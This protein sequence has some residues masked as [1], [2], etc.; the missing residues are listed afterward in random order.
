MAREILF[1]KHFFRSVWFFPAILLL[2]VIIFT[3]LGINGSS[4]GTFRTI[5]YGT[6]SPDPALIVNKPRD[7]RSDEWLVSTQQI[8]AQTEDNF[9]RNNHN[10][11]NGED[12][13]TFDVPYRDWSV[14]FK[15]QNWAFFVLPLDNAFAFKWWSLG[16]LLIVSC[17]FF[18]LAILPG[19]RL[20]AAT[21]ASSLF[22]SAFIQWWYVF[23]TLA[24]V[25]YPL[26]IMT[27]VVYLFRQKIRWKQLALTLL[28][29]YLMTCFALVLYPP[30]QIPCAL[31][32]F[33]FLVGYVLE[34]RKL[35]DKRELI[36]KLLLVAGSTVIA[37]AIVGAFIFTRM[38]TVNSITHTAY[39]GKRTMQSG[40]FFFNHFMSSHLG[41]QFI[42][43]KN[44][45]QYLIDGKSPSNQSETSNFLL[46][47]PFLFLP[48]L[49]LIYKD[50]KRKKDLDWPLILLNGLFV[51]FL[52]EMFV[53]AFTPISKLFF[54]HQVGGARSL[55]GVGLLNLI[56]FALIIRR[57]SRQKSAAITLPHA[58][59]ILYSFAVLVVELHFGLHAH[60]YGTFIL[61]RFV[62]LFSLPIPIVIYLLLTKRYLLAAA[63]YL[64]F[65]VFITIKINPLYQ[66]LG[67]L[68][69]NPLSIAIDR[70]GQ[71][72]DK[73]WVS[74]GGYLEHVAL[75]EGER[76]ISGVYNY[77]QFELWKPIPNTPANNYNRYAHVGFQITDDPTM[78]ASL[79]LVTAD[80]F[81]IKANSCDPYLRKLNIG[82]V[83]T[84]AV[85][86]AG[87]TTLEETV[88]FPKAT[89][90]IYK[91]Q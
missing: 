6:T 4:V 14:I 29:I 20:L 1:L 72:S 49:F 13:S 44:T 16:Y 19:K 26:F 31:V 87:C 75:M 67:T 74:D 15:P 66:G 73:S 78:H 47:V 10:L 71:K 38:D 48:S 25:Y 80:S 83:V 2:P 82:F 3:I 81:V 43:D 42:S 9:S 40:D 8:I 76:S 54:L 52:C 17:Y 51:V 50:I 32:A 28:L 60:S 36:G 77:P 61:L 57:L 45:A 84:T 35:W 18:I 70:I 7:I 5:L 55:I 41:Y 30:F 11:G 62:L 53:P 27:A 79:S 89:I 33:A 69:N 23:G 12:V 22:F 65:S 63:I 59:V 34:N 56:V 64:A 58:A 91:L 46:V 37:V 90:Y 24:S 86:K 39:P 68:T 21:L 85:L 88:P